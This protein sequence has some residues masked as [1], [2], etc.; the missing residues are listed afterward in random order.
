MAVSAFKSTSRRGNYTNASTSSSSSISTT[1][2]DQ[3]SRDSLNK[4]PIRRSRSVSAV[5]RSQLLQEGYG[6]TRDNPL[7]DCSSGS[8]KSPSSE[9]ENL[10]VGKGR[11]DAVSN[12]KRGRMGRA[13]DSAIVKPRERSLSQVNPVRR[14]LRSVSR[15]PSKSNEVRR[16]QHTVILLFYFLPIRELTITV[17]YIEFFYFDKENISKTRK[18]LLL[19]FNPNL[20]FCVSFY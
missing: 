15:G 19:P 1:S 2:R 14:R 16:L 10:R 11:G 18:Q 8:S 7:F 4:S 17:L 3:V 12:D 6:N 20:S 13:L 9:R 5:Q